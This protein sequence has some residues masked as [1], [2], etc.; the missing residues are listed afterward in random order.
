MSE[1]LQLCSATLSVLPFVVVQCLGGHRE[2]CRESRDRGMR[3]RD[4]LLSDPPG[5]DPAA[6]SRTRQ[7]HSAIPDEADRAVIVS[8]RIGDICGKP[9]LCRRDRA[10]AALREKRT[11]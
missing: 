4:V 8:R 3:F 1:I 7:M 11:T 10:A 9:G 6:G 5:G 2:I